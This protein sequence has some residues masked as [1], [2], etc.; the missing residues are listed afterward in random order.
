MKKPVRFTTF[1]AIILK[2]SR[3]LHSLLGEEKKKNQKVLLRLTEKIS[4]QRNCL[5]GIHSKIYIYMYISF[6]VWQSVNYTINKAVLSV[7]HWQTAHYIDTTSWCS[8]PCP[9]R[10]S[11][12]SIPG[13]GTDSG[14]SQLDRA[15]HSGSSHVSFF[16]VSVKQQGD[17]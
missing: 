7:L 5:V 15:L 9:M 16:L 4:L 11:Q 6:Q 8:G 14:W 1:S 3:T 12:S 10:C 17:M 13:V 2:R